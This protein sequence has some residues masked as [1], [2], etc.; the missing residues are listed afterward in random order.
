[1]LS[2]CATAATV[3]ISVASHA[4]KLEIEANALLNADVATAW[5]VLTDYERYVDF[6]PNLQLSRVVARK[7][8]TV[9]VE[10]SGEVVLWR[11]HIPLDVTFEITETAPT[12]LD[13]RVTAGDLR[14]PNSRYVLTPVGNAVRLEYTAKL[15]AGLAPF[16]FID[17][18]AVKQNV[19]KRFEALAVEIERRSAANRSKSGVALSRGDSTF[20]R[21]SAASSAPRAMMVSV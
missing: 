7:G 10:Q 2:Q 5:R 11:V 6:I 19:G 14:A 17:G 12:R 21:V 8:V 3:A 15:D 9:T 13:S 1:M 16:G 4:D 20:T 18:V